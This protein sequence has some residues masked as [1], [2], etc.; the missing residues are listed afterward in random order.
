MAVKYPFKFTKEEF[1]DWFTKIRGDGYKDGFH[2]GYIKGL[3]FGVA[4]I[5]EHV[6]DL[7]S[8]DPD[9]KSYNLIGQFENEVKHCQQMIN[10]RKN[11]YYAVKE[12]EDDSGRTEEKN[13]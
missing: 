1:D 2:E 9:D 10:A 6:I 7:A 12:K 4:F 3:A 8:N 5:Y 11:N 13:S